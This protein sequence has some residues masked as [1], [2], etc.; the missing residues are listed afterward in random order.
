MVSCTTCLNG[1]VNFGDTSGDTIMI[2]GVSNLD[3]SGMRSVSQETPRCGV[4]MSGDVTL[5]G[6]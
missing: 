6:V 5:G 2:A 3:E 4:T 1:D